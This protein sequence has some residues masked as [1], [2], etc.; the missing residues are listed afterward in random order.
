MEALGITS[1]KQ[2]LPI[3]TSEGKLKGSC[4]LNYTSNLAELGI[5]PCLHLNEYKNCLLPILP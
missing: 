1:L 3:N 2:N 4:S 5:T